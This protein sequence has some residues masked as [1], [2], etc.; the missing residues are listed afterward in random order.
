MIAKIMNIREITARK[1][2]KCLANL[3]Q[4]PEINAR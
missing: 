3:F 2:D 1:R 4:G